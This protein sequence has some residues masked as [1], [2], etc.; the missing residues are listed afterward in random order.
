MAYVYFL[1]SEEQIKEKN[2]ILKK[3]SKQFQPG[4]VVVNGTR[5]EYTVKSDKPSLDRF[6]D[7]KVVAEG[8]DEMFVYEEP[9]T[10]NMRGN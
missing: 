1:H 8:I 5:K 9:K 10:V 3:Q 7:A 2:K 6:Y 4:I